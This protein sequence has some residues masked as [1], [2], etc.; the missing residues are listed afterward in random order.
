MGPSPDG[1]SRTGIDF[2]LG[3]N[4]LGALN[5]STNQSYPECNI[6]TLAQTWLCQGHGASRCW[7]DPCVKTFTAS[8]E[9]GQLKETLVES[10]SEWGFTSSGGGA[11]LDIHR[12]HCQRK[13]ILATVQRHESCE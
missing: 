12:V 4:P 3:A 5:P 1:N 10:T 6:I 9:I 11:M 13:S 2:L 7:F 8:V